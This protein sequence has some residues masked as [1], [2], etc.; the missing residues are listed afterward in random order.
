MEVQKI[1]N[2]NVINYNDKKNLQ[3]DN[4]GYKSNLQKR[5]EKD[6]HVDDKELKKIENR[7]NN[8][9]A[10]LNFKIEF[11]LHKDSKRFF[12]KIV[13]KDTKKVIREIPPE[14]LLEF[15]ANF[16]KMLGLLFNGRS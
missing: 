7:I 15:Y 16:E 8:I 9:T 1:E 14:Q 5:M 3:V 2:F 13:D 11:Q 6:V 12:V 4:N 10:S